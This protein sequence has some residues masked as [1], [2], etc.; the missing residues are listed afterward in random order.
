MAGRY[1]VAVGVALALFGAAAEAEAHSL[2]RS[3]NPGC[4][5]GFE[6]PLAVRVRKSKARERARIKWRNA[7]ERKYNQ[8]Y[9]T[10]ARSEEPHYHC[11]KKAGTWRCRFVARP[12]SY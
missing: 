11:K 6:G 10:I 4:K 8:R 7:V 1:V 12:C 3:A 9:T 5:S 2:G